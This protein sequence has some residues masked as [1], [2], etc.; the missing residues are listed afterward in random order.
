MDGIQPYAGAPRPPAT[1]PQAA[2][3]SLTPRLAK[4]PS[5]Y[6]RALRR[7]AWLVLAIGVAL[8]VAGA[9]WAVRQPAIYRATAELVIEPPQYD[10]LLSS[11]VSR[12]V[13][14]RDP[15]T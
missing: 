3:L 1:P 12:D 11:L 5:A 9:L 10:D 8:S 7:R 15:A 14:H 6:L 13:G 4:A 2:T